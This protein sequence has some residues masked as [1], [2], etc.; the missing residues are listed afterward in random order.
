MTNQGLRDLVSGAHSAFVEYSLWVL[1][2]FIWYEEK[3]SLFSYTAAKMYGCS[4]CSLFNS[5]QYTQYCLQKTLSRSIR[6]M[7]FSTDQAMEAVISVILAQCL[8]FIYLPVKQKSRVAF[9]SC[10]LADSHLSFTAKL[11][12]LCSPLWPFATISHLLHLWLLMFLERM[13]RWLHTHLQPPWSLW[14]HLWLYHWS[15]EGLGPPNLH[16]AQG[17]TE[18]CLL[19]RP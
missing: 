1:L 7:Y 15:M 12:W 9:T 4:P 16:Q 18:S 3:E 5:P 17:F 11:W 6:R 2:V 14:T 13:L 10:S 8:Q 19:S